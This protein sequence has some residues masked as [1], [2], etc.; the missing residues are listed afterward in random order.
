MLVALNTKTGWDVPIHVDAASGGFIAPFL[1]PA[2]E[3]D[4]RLPLVKSINASGACVRRRAFPSPAIPMAWPSLMCGRVHTRMIP[5]HT[6]THAPGH[7]FGLVYA[8]IG[9]LAFR[10]K[11]VR[12]S[13]AP[14]T[15]LVVWQ[16]NPAGR[17]D[18]PCPIPHATRHPERQPGRP[19]RSPMPHP[20]R[21][22]TPRSTTTPPPPPPPP[23]PQEGPPRGARLLSQLPRRGPG[24]LHAQLLPRRLADHRAVL[25]RG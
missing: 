13:N 4:F 12:T 18:P 2:L 6:P 7:K 16:V 17:I 21:G 14:H 10:E 19:N 25:V 1:N 3:W 23:P 11:Y 8:G 24:L 22:T 20:T 9:W 5:C 15:E